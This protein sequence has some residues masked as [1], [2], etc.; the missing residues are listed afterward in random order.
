MR[1]VNGEAK[2]NSGAAGAA[3]RKVIIGMLIFTATGVITAGAQGDKTAIPMK[4]GSVEHHKVIE[5]T[6]N[7]IRVATE[8]GSMVIQWTNV[9]SEYEEHPLH[10][11]PAEETNADR[12]APAHAGGRENVEH[13]RGAEREDKE[14]S[15]NRKTTGRAFGLLLFGVFVVF[16]VNIF[17]VWFVSKDNLISG[18]TQQKWNLAALF[19]GPLVL[20]LFL[21]L[22]KVK[23]GHTG[24]PAAAGGGGGRKRFFGGKSGASE[25]VVL[26]TWDGEVVQPDP[27]TSV[28]SGL[29]MVRDVLARATKVG[30]SDVHLDAAKKGVELRFRIDG[31][32]QPAEVLPKETGRRMISAVKMAAGMDIAK[33]EQSQDGAFRMTARDV[34]YDLRVAKAWAVS[35]ETLAVRL[36]PAGGPQAKLTE[37]GMS[38]EMASS[39][40]ETAGQTSGILLLAGPTGTGKTTTIYAILRQ[41]I[42]TG[43]N[44]MTIEDPVEYRLEEATQI[45]LNHKAGDT[46]AGKL[47]ASMR[48]DPDVILVGE[49]RDADTMNVAFDAALTG[50]LVLSTVHASSVLA[51]IGRLQAWGLSSYMINTGLKT[52]ICQR[53][54]RRLCPTCCASYTPE[55][56]ELEFWGMSEYDE[57]ISFYAPAGCDAC[58]RTGFKGRT[59]V[60]RIL[61][62]NNEVR[63]QIKADISTENLQDVVDTHAMGGVV[64]TAQRLLPTGVTSPEELKRTLDIFDFGKHFS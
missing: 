51:A 11:E 49:I 45:S 58:N 27:G 50:H 62:M 17:S 40:Q 6:G 56:S 64:E 23:T 29:R 61:E 26:Y 21:M 3:L 34:A 63:Q 43:R 10:E 38:A 28:A 39:V 22:Y 19:F 48:H 8:Y 35:G 52:V 9:S 41:I 16:W 53:L 44:I 36:L 25:D 60:F 57:D 13:R 2:K 15:G 37:L 47:R 32:L 46:F 55:H 54:V 42:G 30:A 4:D 7:G 59:A 14:V 20:I 1:F 24:T 12:D 18:R 5:H 31:V 33:K